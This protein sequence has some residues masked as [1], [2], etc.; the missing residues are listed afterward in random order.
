MFALKVLFPD[1][2]AARDALAR[3][4]SALEAPRSGPAEYYEVLEQILA[5]GCPLEHAIYAE[6]DVVAC[7]IRGLDETRAA[8]AEAAFLDA[9]ALEVI[10][11]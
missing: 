10:A 3:L 8:M 2:D 6:K 11:E 5:E 9:G 4:R 7:T 1:R